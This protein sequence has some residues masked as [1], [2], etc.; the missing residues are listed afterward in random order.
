M[1]DVNIKCVH[2]IAP[3]L[4][5]I[6]EYPL[7]DRVR[8]HVCERRRDIASILRGED[9]RTLVVVGPCSIHDLDAC[10]EYADR[11]AA[12]SR[13]KRARERYLVVMRVCFEKP[14][15]TVDWKGFIYDPDLNRTND[16][17]KGV[18]LARKFLLHV[19][20]IGLAAGVEFLDSITPQYFSDLVSWGF[21]GAR[22]SESQVHRQLASGVSCPIGFK[23][24]TSGDIDVALNAC[25]A[26]AV[27]HTF[28]GITCRG[29]VAAYHTTGNDG[30]HVILRG[31]THGP[32]LKKGS[33]YLAEHGTPFIVDC[34]HGNVN[35][36]CPRQQ[37]DVLSKVLG[38]PYMR[39][40]MLESHLS[41]G[42]QD[43][44]HPL[45]RGVSITDA[46][47]SFNDTISALETWGGDPGVH[48]GK[49]DFGHQTRRVRD[50]CSLESQRH[51]IYERRSG[52]VNWAHGVLCT[53]NPRDPR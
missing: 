37:I 36:D 22:T 17:E 15:T 44:V 21:I 13:S 16:I 10:T 39:G 45:R 3:P 19:N 23:N 51:V 2:P 50:R 48:Q 42:K 9:R 41:E 47:L 1:V 20:T 27:P 24:S 6:S 25:V 11:L 34:S 35:K 5:I 12:W 53:I 31:S 46:C 18:R 49:R 8:S 4:R 14:R 32:N 33:R 40:V 29:K 26:A 38:L 43:L 30:T 52:D 7:S 28:M